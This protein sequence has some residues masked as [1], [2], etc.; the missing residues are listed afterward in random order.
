MIL[1]IILKMAFTVS[2]K[3][4]WL[5][6][7]LT[8]IIIIIRYIYIADFVWFCHSCDVNT[9]NIEMTFLNLGI[10]VLVVYNLIDCVIYLDLQIHWVKK[11][12]RK[13]AVKKIT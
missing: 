4:G 13:S 10:K 3:H 12:H 8:L 7:W 1:F 9:Q 2:G 11:I 5:A 6:G